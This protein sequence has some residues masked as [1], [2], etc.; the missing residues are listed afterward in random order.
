MLVGP[1]AYG[2]IRA[3]RVGVCDFENSHAR[4]RVIHRDGHGFPERRSDT[5]EDCAGAWPQLI[6]DRSALLFLQGEVGDIAAGYTDELGSREIADDGFLPG[7]H[8]DQA[9][10]HVVVKFYADV[11]AVYA[12]ALRGETGNAHAGDQDEWQESRALRHRSAGFHNHLR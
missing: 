1:A 10:V 4:K 12:G 6:P 2:K 9:A 8:G 7:A 5:C 11:L 3:S